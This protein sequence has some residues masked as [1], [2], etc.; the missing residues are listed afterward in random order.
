VLIYFTGQNMDSSNSQGVGPAAVAESATPSVPAASG[1]A[2]PAP[3]ASSLLVAPNPTQ[4]SDAASVLFPPHIPMPD[5]PKR[6]RGRPPGSKT[7][8][9]PRINPPEPESIAPAPVNPTGQLP[10]LVSGSAPVDYDALGKMLVTV[11]TGMAVQ[12]GGREWE[13]TQDEHKMLSDATAKYLRANNYADIPPGWML[14]ICVCAYATP[15][16]GAPTVQAKIGNLG[17]KVKGFFIRQPA[18]VQ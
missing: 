8:T 10:A 6:G 16:I 5:A 1:A 15:R 9:G 7:K 4:A 14:V 13:A 17:R 18:S 2:T 3:D 11:T 12:F